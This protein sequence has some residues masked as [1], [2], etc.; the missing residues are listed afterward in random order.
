MIT[1]SVGIRIF[2]RI[3][4]LAIALATFASLSSAATTVLLGDQAVEPRTDSN[5]Q[6]VAEVFKTTASS[7]GTLNKLTVYVDSTSAATALTTGLYADGNGH[8][9]TLLTQGTITAPVAG[10]WTDVAVPTTSVT[11]GTTYWIAL[12][13]PT[14]AG[15][16]RFRNRCCGGGTPAESS[17]QSTLTSLPVSWST[18]KT[19]NDGPVSAYGSSADSPILVVSPTSLSFSGSLGGNDPAPQ[20][21]AVTNGGG[22]SLSWSAASNATWLSASPASGTAPSTSSVTTSLAG[23]SAGTYTATVTVT[24][25]GA[26]SSPQTIAVTVTVSAPDSTSPSVAVSAPAAGATVSGQ[27]QVS[28][29]ASDNVAVAGVQFKLDGANLGVEDTSAPY[30]TSWD[31]TVSSNGAHSLSALA[32]D[33]AGNQTLSG[34]VTVTVQNTST[35]VLLGDQTIEPK[36]DSNAAGSAEAF[37]T[38]ATASGS[39]TRLSVYLDPL[40]ATSMLSVGLYSDANGHPGSLLTQATL[41]AP[42]AGAWNMIS[43]P[44]ATVTN[45]SNYWIALL[46]P[47]GNGTPR[48]RDRCCGSGT[49]SESS[50][51][52]TLSS[53]PTTWTTGTA[54]KDG[55][56]SAYANGAGAQL[57]P[58]DQIGRWAAPQDWP[59]VAVH[60]ALLPTGNVLAWDGF[61]A[62]PDSQHIWNPTTATFTPVPYGRNLFCSGHVLLADGRTLVLGGHLQA[63]VGLPD[64]TLYDPGTNTWTRAPDMTV[65]RWYPTATVLPSGKV[66][67]VSGDNI[68]QNVPNQPHSLEDQSHSLPELYDPVSN[69]WTDLTS[70]QLVMPLYPFMFVLDDGRILDAGPD[71]TT[72]I[73]DPATW[74]WSTIGPSPFDGMSAVMYRPGKIMKAGSWADPDFSGAK[75]YASS[76]RV[77]A[78]DMNQ[79]SPAWREVAPM[80]FA[81]SYENLTLLPDGTVLASGGQATSDGV[82]LTQAVLPAEIWNPDTETWTT[83][84]SE[85]IGREYHSTAL[86]LP[87]GR[88]LMA[89]GGQLP[90]SPATNETNGEVYSPPYLF[91]GARPTISATP[92]TVQYG[93]GFTVST[94][95]AAS[96]ASVALIRTPAVTHAFDQN[97]RFMRLSFTQSGGSLTV[98]AP[99]NA[100]LVPPGYYML[101]LVNT[102]GVPSVASFVRFPAPYED[103]QPPTPPTSLAATGGTGQVSLTW[104]SSTDNVG[105][106]RYDV[107]RSTTSGFTPS[108]TNRIAQPTGTSYTDLGLTAGTYYYR[109]KAQDAAGNLSSASNEATATA[110]ADTTSPSVAVSAPAAGATVSG[111]VQVSA[112]ASDNVA[113]AGVQF[114]LDG[115]NL[116]VEDTSAPYTTSWDTTVSS[117]GAHSLSALARDAAGNQT[118]SGSVTVT[119]QNTSTSVLLGDQTIEPKTD[120]NAAGSAEAFRTSATAS[121]SLTRLSVYLDP[122]S[123]TS[124]LSVGLYSDANGHPGSLL[125]QA[126]L[127]APQAG[128]WNMISVPAA[129]VT[130]GSN[131]WIA[132]LAPNGNGTP[133][134]R[135]RCCGSGTPSE[136]SSQTTLSSLPTTWTTGTAYK[137][138]PLSAYANG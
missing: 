7:S 2:G 93:T 100:N 33:A 5:A 11:S 108:L 38:S 80:A 6:G 135:D 90:G 112:T 51:Q 123:A 54:Y 78:I 18:G 65:G 97:Q 105:V 126:T 82:D 101:F 116:G 111:Q 60:M 92:A 106:A 3:A 75:L 41:L 91:K 66:L 114:K 34:S 85:Q 99:A 14:G 118:L 102:N 22:G 30:T 96:I 138:G 8:P 104:T 19:Y 13:G 128:A 81:R 86:L 125:T 87:D 133:R 26:Q 73:I 119:V 42:Q 39:L 31:T 62:G 113:V 110:M 72:R 89:G 29:T 130:N 35:S 37:R 68:Q 59:I 109:V 50:S 32:R 43:V 36:T 12:L 88:V 67:V 40:S 94:P 20:S 134:F 53:L 56:L 58:A 25:G 46:A 136:S 121:G 124:M 17:S 127:L 63:D 95:D 49:P 4:L 15:T 57:P 98:Q 28:A 10:T 1:S 131:Y 137:D 27:V 74:T 117:N 24:A 84:A 132:L 16:L 107:Y 79:P 70:A 69:S 9:G 23:L 64:T 122:L 48:F 45:G 77:A 44:A 61:A 52:T 129:T 71:T 83:V 120:S 103:L 76:N 47:N 21:V 115:A 55:P